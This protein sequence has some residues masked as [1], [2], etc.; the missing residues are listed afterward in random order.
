MAFFFHHLYHTF[1]G[2]YDLVAYIVS[3]G[4][5]RN[6]VTGIIPYITGRRV[7]EIGF[8]PGHLQVALNR[9]GNLSVFGLDES[10]QMA[11]LAVRRLRGA[12]TIESVKIVRSRVEQ[13]PFADSSFESVVATFPTPYI[14]QPET[15]AQ[16]R[17]VLSPGGRLVVL[18]AARHTRNTLPARMAEWLFAVT[19]Q[20]PPEP[21]TMHRLT[22]VFGQSGL[23][24]SIHWENTASGK[25]LLLIVEKPKSE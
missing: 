15:I 2:A 17:R 18:L 12:H 25:L 16:V 1:A 6:W 19:G 24:A 13:M 11:R 20:A 9:V 21:D 8:G 23:D 3:L 5:W 7:L 22:E 4:Q 14:V 10:P